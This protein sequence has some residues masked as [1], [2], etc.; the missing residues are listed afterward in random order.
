VIYEEFTYKGP[1]GSGDAEYYQ[2]VDVGGQRAE[3]R[4]WMQ[5]FDEVLSVLF[6]VALSGYDQKLYEDVNQNRLLEE[7]ELFGDTVHQKAFEN[8]SFIVFLNKSDLFHE[9]IG[10]IAFN[11]TREWEHFEGDPHNGEQVIKYIK[12]R[13]QA[14]HPKKQLYFHITQATDPENVNTVFKVCHDIIVR[15]VLRR[16]GFA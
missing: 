11:A 15:E 2:I 6:V 7:F 8:T 14:C 5:C 12:Q 4:K 9:K 3:R 13:L 1:S 10:Q 16:T